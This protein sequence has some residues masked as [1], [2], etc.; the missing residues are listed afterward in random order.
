MLD[1]KNKGNNGVSSDFSHQQN[2]KRK[3]SNDAE[4]EI[5]RKVQKHLS[6]VKPKQS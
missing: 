3:L 1:L 6:H 2:L 4:R 5:S